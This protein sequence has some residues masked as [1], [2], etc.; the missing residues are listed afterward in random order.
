MEKKNIIQHMV[1]FNLKY[2]VDAPETAK[3][4]QDGREILSAIPTVQD[5]EVL[6]QVSM[7][8]NYRFGF[9]M[10]FDNQE[11]YTAYNE[12]PSHVGFVKER[13]LTE[14]TEFLEIDFTRND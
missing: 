7:K 3:F 5:F 4:L 14:V 10:F 9:S 12:H 6:N 2:P 1:I 13:W 8:N 11:A